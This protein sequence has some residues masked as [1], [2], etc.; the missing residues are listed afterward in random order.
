MGQWIRVTTPRDYKMLVRVADLVSVYEQHSGVFL[1]MRDDKS[2][3]GV[4]ES[5]D[6]I[7]VLLDEAAAK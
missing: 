4:L 1:V 5:V 7:A 2:R 6:E 3:I